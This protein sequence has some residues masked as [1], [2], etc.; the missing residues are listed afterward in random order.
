M[1][2]LPKDVEKL[3]KGEVEFAIKRLR[4]REQEFE[5]VQQTRNALRNKDFIK[6]ERELAK[7]RMQL[8]QREVEARLRRLEKQ[9]KKS[10]GCCLLPFLIMTMPFV[11]VVVVA[12]NW[13]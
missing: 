4:E 7:K 10:G 11:A 13:H 3:R 9:S 6:R 1:P 12:I 8:E 5:Q 2:K